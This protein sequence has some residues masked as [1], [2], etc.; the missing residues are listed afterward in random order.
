MKITLCITCYSGDHHYLHSLLPLFEG[1]TQLP[2]ETLIVCSEAT[3]LDINTTLPKFLIHY[4]KHRQNAA[5]ARN[6]GAE[7]AQNEVIVFFDVDDIPHPQKIETTKK[8]LGDYDYMLHSYNKFKSNKYPSLNLTDIN[9]INTFT[10]IELPTGRKH[11]TNVKCR[12]KKIHH[13]HI[14]VKRNIFNIIKFDED[15]SRER[16]EDSLFCQSLVKGNYK[17]I[18][19]D[20][21]LILYRQ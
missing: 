6:K 11:S 3:H 7:L 8:I 18:F 20:F 16:S 4:N 15:K 10:D 19:A 5:W 9:K 2:D 13:A 17:G 21:P 14:A 12:D 1:Q